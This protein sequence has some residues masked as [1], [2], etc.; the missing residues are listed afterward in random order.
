MNPARTEFVRLIEREPIP[1]ARAALLIA[2]EEYPELD[3]ERYLDHLASLG[4]AAA[5]AVSE[6]A[7]T[8]ERVQLLSDFLFAQTGFAGNREN[9]GDPRNSFLNEVL[10][11][12][13]GIP[14][15]LSVVYLEV[16]RRA[17]LNLHGVSFPS[18]FLVKAVD[19]RGELIIDPFNGG[20]ILGLD[21]LRERLNRIYGR[22][23]ELHPAMLKAASARQILA[24]M[25]RNLKAIHLS[26][27]DWPRALGALDRIL[28][29]E[30]RAVEEI[31]ER[32]TLYERLE[33]FAAAL[34][35]FQ[36]FLTQAPEHPAADA[37]RE[38][39]VR[40]ARQVARIN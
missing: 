39:A 4:R 15:T 18:H 6:G 14:I 16:G 25:L 23:V 11:R 35:D 12:R 22:P 26:G 13:L 21:E 37:A 9:Y 5:R 40:L 36:S 20:A 34:E 1:L 2:K 28:L 29:L 32:A 3:V 24:R 7:D 38:A 8:V 33:C 30:P 17:G 10:E 19:R 27:A 31:L